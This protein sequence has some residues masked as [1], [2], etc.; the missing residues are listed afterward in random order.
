MPVHVCSL[1]ELVQVAWSKNRTMIAAQERSLPKTLFQRSLWARLQG[2]FF[3][4]GADAD[5]L[6]LSPALTRDELGFAPT[7]DTT[8][9]TTTNTS[10]NDLPRPRRPRRRS[11]TFTPSLNALDEHLI[12]F[13]LEAQLPS[14]HHVAVS[15]AV[16]VA[17]DANRIYRCCK[18]IEMVNPRASHPLQQRCELLRPI[19][20]CP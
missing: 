13:D 1:G 14:R 2:T 18:R 7:P 8:T 10:T 11:M 5:A 19:I 6:S 12:E 16:K 17:P 3:A 4:S 15:P 9:S 20:N